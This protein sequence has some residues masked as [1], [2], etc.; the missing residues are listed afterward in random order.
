[1]LP[2]LD[3]RWHLFAAVAQLGSLTRAADALNSPQSVISRQ[4]AQLETQCGGKLFR[5]TGRGVVLTEFGQIVHARIVP[6]I[7]E[8]DQLADEILTTNGIPIGEVHVGLLPS[9]VPQFAGRLFRAAREQLPRV[10]LHL[11]EG[12]SAQL[13]EWLDAGRLDLALLLREGQEAGPGVT[14][15]RSMALD[16]I[17]PAGDPALAGDHIAFA[18]LACLPLI[19]PA[20]PHVLRKRLD[21]LARERGL[22]LT[23]AMEA[24]TIELQKELAIAGAGYA[25]VASVA[26][27]VAGN[28]RLAAARI[29]QPE[30]MRS[31]VLG[32]TR[33]RPHTLAT[34]AVS[35]LIASLFAA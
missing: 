6:M 7:A 11:A 18:A 32:T 29:V 21:A 30:L 8:A 26:G 17:G 5:R 15:L 25:I 22:R 34:R 2:I 12:A 20:E 16:L 28:A 14:C 27:T 24:D 1:M 3:P 13:E 10:R 33:H 31:I 4:I 23:V 19:V 35:R 9:S